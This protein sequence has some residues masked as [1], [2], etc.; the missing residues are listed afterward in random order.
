MSIQ[1]ALFY[2]KAYDKITGFEDWGN[3]RTRKIADHAITFYLRSLKTG[4]KMPLGYGLCQSTTKTH[5]LV[6]CIKEWLS[7]IIISGFIPVATICDQGSANIA[8][9]NVLVAD[10]NMFRV[11][12][13]LRPSK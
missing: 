10:S 2:N 11:T 13:N 7:N 3:K 5:Q 8:A 1:P 12:R 9:I 6:H 4:Q